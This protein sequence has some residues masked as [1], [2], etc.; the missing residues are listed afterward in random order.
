MNPGWR[1]SY[2]G[3]SS[4]IVAISQGNR[5]VAVLHLCCG[6]RY[7]SAAKFNAAAVARGEE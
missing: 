5:A 1:I 4:F 6:S 2:I 3:N 7:T